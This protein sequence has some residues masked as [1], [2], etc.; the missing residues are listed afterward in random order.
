MDLKPLTK[1]IA[2]TTLS[3]AV[4]AP[5]LAQ[6]AFVEDAKAS[7]TMKN[8]YIN[9]DN[10]DGG[11]DDKQWGQGFILNVQSGFTEGT[12]GFGLDAVAMWGIKL[13]DSS[14]SSKKG[15]ASSQLF[16]TKTNGHST[17]DFAKLGVTAKARISQTE[18]RVGTLQPNL[19][20]LKTND[21]RLLPQMFNGGQI[22]MNEI[23]NL[24]VVAGLLNNAVGRA[25]S[26]R[27][28]LSVSGS[29]EDSNKFWFA[30]ADYKVMP[31]LTLQ[32]YYANLEDFYKQN[33]L[34]LNH[35][36]NIADNQSFNTDIRYFSTKADGNN[37]S[38]SKR[39]NYAIGGYTKNGNG[40]IDNNTWSLAFTYKLDKH[41]IM[42]GHQR[43]SKNSDFTQLNQGGLGEGAQGASVWLHT[44]RLINNFATAGTKSSWVDYKYD[45][46]GVGVP[47][48]KAG[49]SYTK[50]TN[51]YLKNTTKGHQW[52]RDIA[53]D[54]TIQEGTFKNVT[55]SARNGT[56]RG[57]N[58]AVKDTDHNRVY[59]TYTL[60][61]L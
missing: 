34:G 36:F 3:A 35:T 15:R 47:G 27:T 51:M 46:A 7:L 6:A 49:V 54:Y 33:F 10:R 14:T 16:P 2:F 40:K 21:G 20:I 11:V 57:H 59:V 48:L 28:G 18:A 5:S 9:N 25:S 31:D 55:F 8:F 45:F 44:D 30:G 17:D 12:V 23:E 13:D 29:A 24:S 56:L 52:E 61:L 37:K 39:G 43:V 32:Y 19:P 4:L 60:P 22:T 53:L 26:N 41:S 1:A 58:G 42:L 50:G 38:D